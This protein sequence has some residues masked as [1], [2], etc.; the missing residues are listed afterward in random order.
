[1]TRRQEQIGDQLQAELADLFARH[2][3]HPVLQ[4]VM[5]SITRVEVTAD[6][7]KARV[8]VSVFNAEAS[9]AEVLDALE[10][11]GGFLHR[12]LT[13]R[14]H[15]RRVP[16]LQ[17]RIDHSLA[18]ADRLSTLMREVARD[19]GRPNPFDPEPLAGDRSEP[20]ELE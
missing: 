15:L 17:F 12:E 6:L 2:V 18:E 9:E 11:S 13:R 1:M 20:D 16:F 8:H 14:L 5:L 4:D 7:G 19:E 3:K 10:R